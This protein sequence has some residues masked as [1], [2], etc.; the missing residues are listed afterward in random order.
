MDLPKR[1]DQQLVDKLINFIQ[2]SSKDFPKIMIGVYGDLNSLV[3]AKLAKQAM[4]DNIIVII[5][6][7]DDPARTS[8][9][10]A[11]CQQLTLN[12]YILRRGA[13]YRSEIS[14]YGLHT[15][16]KQNQ[17]FMRFINY[18]LQ[19]QAGQMKAGLI[20]TADKSDRILGNKPEGFYGHIMPFYSL[21]KFEIFNLAKFL[22][23]P[24][25]FIQKA[26]TQEKID[27]ALFLLT[28]KQLTPEEISEQLHIDLKWLKKL[29]SGLNK[30]YLTSPTSQ[31]II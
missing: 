5:F 13:A 31:F 10:T 6:D 24:E 8:N 3:A 22:K 30:H 25:Q 16:A 26:L 28:E 1:V 23:L 2:N 21:Y 18:H 4:G 14:S 17:F 12:T 29:K 19:I 7:F 9:L 20:D 27:S 11:F 15:P